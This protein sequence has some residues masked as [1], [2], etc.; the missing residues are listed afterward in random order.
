MFLSLLVLEIKS[1]KYLPY[2][3]IHTHIH[4]HKQFH[5]ITF[6]GSGDLKTYKSDANFDRKRY[7]LYITI[8]RLWKEKKVFSKYQLKIINPH[9]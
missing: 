5:K 8:A 7:F 3:H 4:A 1:T 2:S 6:L 9:L